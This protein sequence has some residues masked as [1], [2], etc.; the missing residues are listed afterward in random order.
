MK[1]SLGLLVRAVFSWVTVWMLVGVCVGGVV[2]MWW[3]WSRPGPRALPIVPVVATFLV[4][5]GVAMVMERRHRRE[6]ESQPQ[7][8]EPARVVVPVVCRYEGMI[9]GMHTWIAEEPIST[10]ELE[11]VRVAVGMR[12]PYTDVVVHAV[13]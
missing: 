8:V 7:P 2:V 10:H 3:E 13:R 9:L 11:F 12:A 5:M 1:R 4:V 6:E